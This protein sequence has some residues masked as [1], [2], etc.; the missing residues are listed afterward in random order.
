MNPRPIHP[1]PAIADLHRV[2][3]P[4]SDHHRYVCLDRNERLSPLPPWFTEKVRSRISSD[5]LTQYPYQNEFLSLLAQ[6]VGLP[7]N[8]VLLASGSDAG[9]KALFQAYVGAGDRVVM[10]D[11]SYAMLPIYAQMFEART[12]RVG[13][14]GDLVVNEESL[15]E[16]V[17][18]GVRLVVLANPNQPTG[19]L[20]GQETIRRVTV[21]AAEIGALVAIDEAYYPFSDETVLPLIKDHP[22]LLVLRTFSKAS[23][24]AGLRIG[25]VA[26]ESEIV[27][28]LFKVR[29]AHDVNSAA[30]LCA[31]L[32]LEHPEIVNG[33]K[34][35]VK[36]GAR[37]LG[38]RARQLGLFP[39]PTH[40]NFLLIRVAHR[41]DPRRLVETLKALGYLVKGPFE[42]PCIADCIRVTLGPPELMLQFARCLE[43]AL[44]PTAC[45]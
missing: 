28:N 9:I 45:S 41:V 4:G 43:S 19:T 21:R 34:A 35:E 23:G 32:I 20:L 37:V 10:L 8:M 26:G 3:D 33:Y 5:L 42:S 13:F 24:L 25:W 22:N 38:E 14:G 30:M 31:G 44:T 36:E 27:R 7:E 11:P 12:V 39:L 18:A 15:L 17:V 40:T 6:K 29:S 16:A 2:R 1:Q